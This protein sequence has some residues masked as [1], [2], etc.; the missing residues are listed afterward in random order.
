MVGREARRVQ[1]DADGDVEVGERVA[2]EEGDAALEEPEPRGTHP[3]VPQ[4]ALHPAQQA[5]RQLLLLLA[6]QH[7][8]AVR[9]PLPLLL[10]VRQRVVRVARFARLHVFDQHSQTLHVCARAFIQRSQ[11]LIS[12]HLFINFYCAFLH[13][14]CLHSTIYTYSTLQYILYRFLYI[15]CSGGG[16]LHECQRLAI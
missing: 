11:A 12:F 8:H 15:L 14:Y 5:A 10:H 3:R 7:R 1:N 16:D 6:A 9:A 4:S 2:D 13:I